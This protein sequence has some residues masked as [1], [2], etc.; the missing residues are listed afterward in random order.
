MNRAIGAA[1]ESL[2]DHLR[3]PRRPGRA[4]DHFP[5]LLFLEAERLL[6]RVGVGLVQL[7]AG[8]VV[9][10]PGLGVVDPQLPFTGDDL[11][12]ADSYFH[13]NECAGRI[14]V[15]PLEQQRPVRAAEAERIR[16]RIARSPPHA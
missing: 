8:V 13:N 3:G 1:R 12:D 14:L 11:L 2:T 4:Y 7:E 5:A 16:E 10:D 9:P 6:E 15:E